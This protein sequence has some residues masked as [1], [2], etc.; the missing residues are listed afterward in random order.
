MNGFE[1]AAAQ[2]IGMPPLVWT[3][4][5]LRDTN[6]DGLSDI[7]WRNSSTGTTVVW[8]MS[9]FTRVAAE[10]IGSVNSDWQLH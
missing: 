5:Q 2:S 7:L 3:V 10:A 8:R 6:G 4:E 1:R 9:G